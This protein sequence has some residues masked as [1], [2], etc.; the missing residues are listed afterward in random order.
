MGMR[1]GG[2]RLVQVEV[3][4]RAIGDMLAMRIIR[5]SEENHHWSSTMP[6][7]SHASFLPIG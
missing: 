7:Q 1:H 4:L 6:T 3:F 2:M 5:N